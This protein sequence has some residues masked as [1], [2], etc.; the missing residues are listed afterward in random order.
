MLDPDVISSQKQKCSDLGKITSDAW[1]GSNKCFRSRILRDDFVCKWERASGKRDALC[2]LLRDGSGPHSSPAWALLLHGDTFPQG[3]DP[4]TSGKN[5]VP[6]CPGVL[7]AATFTATAGGTLKQKEDADI[8]NQHRL[9]LEFSWGKAYGITCYSF[10]RQTFFWGD[11]LAKQV[12]RLYCENWSETLK[13]TS[14]FPEK[15]NQRF[16]FFLL[17]KMISGLQRPFEMLVW[18]G[19]AFFIDRCCC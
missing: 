2:S 16:F 15:T 1:R 13:T 18:Q 10:V 3:T 5:M 7:K 14:C 6:V 11:F 17:R 12:F 8:S 19:T 9:V 4:G